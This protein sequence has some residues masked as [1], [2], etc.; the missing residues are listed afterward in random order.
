MQTMTQTSDLTPNEA[1]QV[2]L[3]ADYRLSQLEKAV[4]E[5]FKNNSKQLE[6]LKQSY[7]PITSFTTLK[8]EFEVVKKWKES[9]VNKI[10]FGAVMMMVAMVLAM[11][12][13]DKLNI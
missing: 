3:L 7:A 11:Y 9:I 1:S 5:G 6:D 2:T 12:G 10:A 13:I 8:D 4:V